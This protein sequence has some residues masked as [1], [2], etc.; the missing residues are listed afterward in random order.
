MVEG[1]RVKL[2]NGVNIEKLGETTYFSNPSYTMTV[3]SIRGDNA[4][5]I[6]PV[7]NLR[8]IVSLNRLVVVND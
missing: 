6:E 4:W 7:E 3:D 8:Q 1:D 5:V 2:K